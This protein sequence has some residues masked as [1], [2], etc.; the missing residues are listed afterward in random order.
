MNTALLLISII[1]SIVLVVL[2]LLFSA[3]FLFRC[4]LARIRAAGFST[5]QPT[6]DPLTLKDL[7]VGFFGY[8]KGASRII[9]LLAARHKPVG[10][11][12]LVDDF[13][14]DE[15]W[16][17][18]SDELPASAMLAVLGLMQVAG[19]VRITRHGM[20]ITEVGREVHRRIAP[21][22]G[23]QKPHAPAARS[24]T[25]NGHRVV[26][27]LSSADRTVLRELRKRSRTLIH[28]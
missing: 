28:Q 9:R 7:L 20:A 15:Q 19:V 22:P 14:F 23:V 16:R 6:R 18:D 25:G 27:T 5:P 10:Y 24:S 26:T 3:G 13:R 4:D 8:S 1:G 21:S 11:R 12:A 2:A 17:R